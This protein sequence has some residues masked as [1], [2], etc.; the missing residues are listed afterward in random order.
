MEKSKKKLEMNQ[1]QMSK[2]E[3]HLL[4]G[5]ELTEEDQAEFEKVLGDFEEWMKSSI[6]ERMDNPKDPLGLKGQDTEDNRKEKVMD[7]LEKYA[8]RVHGE[9]K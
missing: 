1:D 6:K 2:L 8:D 9:K 3:K 4:N 7:Y 5:D